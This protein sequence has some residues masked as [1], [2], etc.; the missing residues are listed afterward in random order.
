[1]DIIEII[2]DLTGGAFETYPYIQGIFAIVLTTI[3]F[4]TLYNFLYAIEYFI[5]GGR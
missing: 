1:M 4:I 2:N 3:I 5:R